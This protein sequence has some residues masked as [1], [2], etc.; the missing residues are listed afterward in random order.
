MAKSSASAPVAAAEPESPDA[1]SSDA[2]PAEPVRDHF[3]H[4]VP[5]L[6]TQDEAA[7]WWAAHPPDPEPETAAAAAGESAETPENPASSDSEG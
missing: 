7:A 5:G 3:I 6:M 4:G 1:P 2:P